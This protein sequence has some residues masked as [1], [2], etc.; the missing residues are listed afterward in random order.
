VA[1]SR[2]TVTNKKSTQQIEKERQIKLKAVQQVRQRLLAQF[3]FSKLP[4]GTSLHF[5]KVRPLDFCTRPCPSSSSGVNIK[6]LSISKTG[7]N[8]ITL[9][10]EGKVGPK[11]TTLPGGRENKAT[12]D[13]LL[14]VYKDSYINI[15]GKKSLYAESMHLLDANGKKYNALNGIEGLG[16]SG[17]NRNAYRATLPFNT[18][19]RF[20]ISFPM[21]TTATDSLVFVSPRLSG[22]QSGWKM[23]IYNSSNFQETV[24]L[25]KNISRKNI[26]VAPR[27]RVETSKPN[28]KVSE[29][30]K[31]KI[32][33]TAPLVIKNIEQK[34]IKKNEVRCMLPNDDIVLMV[35]EACKQAAG[36]PIN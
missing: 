19:S 33:D 34:A 29:P 16:I 32:I 30:Q 22:H 2:E 24:N 10:F 14:F 26:T 25:L 6:L 18:I 13:Y 15:V 5:N 12:A 27:D 31:A 11:K 17:F 35:R 23:N 1:K 36:I 8:I 9:E 20:T 21:P 28:L 3:N 7:N 4:V